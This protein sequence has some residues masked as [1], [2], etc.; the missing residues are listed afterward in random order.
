MHGI[1]KTYYEKNKMTPLVVRHVAPPSTT[2]EG[3]R[4]Q[5]ESSLRIVDIMVAVGGIYLHV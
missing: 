4:F 3:A 2:L 5:R 1:D